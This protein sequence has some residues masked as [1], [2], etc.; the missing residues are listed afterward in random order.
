MINDS[1]R[2]FFTER[3]ID[4]I[5]NTLSDDIVLKNIEDQINGILLDQKEIQTSYLPYFIQR[6]NYVMNKYKDN[7]EIT[8]KI[9]SAIE[10]VYEEIKVLITEKF[11][12]KVDFSESVTFNDRLELI[13]SFYKF[14]IIDLQDNCINF[15]VNYITTERK[16]LVKAFKPN[17]NKKDL[18]FVNLKKYLNNENIFIVFNLDE[19]IDSIEIEDNAYLIDLMTKNDPEMLTNFYIRNVLMEERFSDVGFESNLFETLKPYI[20]ANDSLQM[21]VKSRLI[22]I[23]KTN[24]TK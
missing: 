20:K 8:T 11:N 12:I 14:F 19:I 17:T 18:S 3:D 16:N 5:I 23:F 22:K 21:K 9:K 7:E 1:N 4:Q 6:Y 13:E 24:T 10:K 2:D 15:L